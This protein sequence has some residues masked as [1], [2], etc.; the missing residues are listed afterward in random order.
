MSAIQLPKLAMADSE[1]AHE[2][3]A[4]S[5]TPRRT[6]SARHK[7]AVSS[8]AVPARRCEPQPVD[9]MGH[10]TGE[11]LDAQ[12]EAARRDGHEPTPARPRFVDR[13][14]Y[15]S[16]GLGEQVVAEALDGLVGLDPRWSYL[17]SIPVGAN[18]SDIDHL[19]VGP[20]GV[21]TISAKNHDDGRVWVGGDAVNVNGTWQQD[22]RS[23]RF[24]AERAG[25][26]LTAAARMEVSVRGLLVPVGAELVVR[27]QPTDV[28]V[29]D[30]SQLVDFLIAQPTVLGTYQIVL[31]LSCARLSSTWR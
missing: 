30:A 26:L 7:Y 16:R 8:D 9:L 11:L 13:R 28:M 20:G 22:V 25:N 15:S 19:V 27:E 18:N 12:S 5:Y 6:L 31:V 10:P 21:F 4:R 17:N 24:E 23:S 14:A 1:S 3:G 2:D 29:L